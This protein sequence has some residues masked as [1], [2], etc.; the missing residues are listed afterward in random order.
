MPIGTWSCNN[1]GCSELRIMWQLHRDILA[2]DWCSYCGYFVRLQQQI[3]L[4]HSHR[5][6]IG[7]TSGHNL[8]QPKIKQCVKFYLIGFQI[9]WIFDDLAEFSEK[10]LEI[11]IQSSFKY[12][13]VGKELQGRAP[14]LLLLLMMI[15][16]RY[17]LT[18]T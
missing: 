17:D 2:R 10:I 5:Y 6:D 7:G 12:M 9:S 16:M 15:M 3:L 8:R 13:Y 14:L 18:G 11:K 1:A 4:S